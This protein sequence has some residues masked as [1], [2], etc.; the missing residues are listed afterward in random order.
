[1]TGLVIAGGG[2]AGCLAALA[3]AEKRP[4]LPLLLIEEGTRF[5]GNH[6][7]S[8][9]DSDVSTEHRALVDPLVARRWDDHDVHFPRRSR[10]IDLGYSSVRSGDLDRLVRARLRPDQYRLGHAV[11]EVGPDHV[12]LDGGER[13]SAHGVVDARGPGPMPGLDLAWQKFVGRIYRFEAPHGVA[14]PLIMDARVCQDLG[15][16]FVYLLPFSE[17]ELL[18]EDTY[19]CDSPVLDV[20]LVRGR[21]ESYVAR[22]GRGPAVHVHEETGVLPVVLGGEVAALWD[23]HPPAARLGLRG[24]FFHPTTGYSL[25]DAVR[26]AALLAG[27]RDLSGPALH[28]LFRARA[29]AVWRER[30]F[31]RL[32]NRM[33]FRAAPPRRR[34]RVLEHFY[35]LPAPVIA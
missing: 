13:I 27:Q 26:N 24:G 12:L 20:P 10:T 15:Y 9:F 3:V 16:R 21:V 34:Y 32:L 5:G 30:G 2:L 11:R 7:W 29:E 33:L 8:F 14:R 6:I 19:Y 31:F 17:T 1:M 18:V 25:P 4:D 22:A 35:R 28:R 23:G